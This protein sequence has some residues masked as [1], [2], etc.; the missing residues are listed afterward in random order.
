MVNAL[1]MRQNLTCQLHDS[2]VRALADQRENRRQQQS[3]PVL[4]SQEQDTGSFVVVAKS[5]CTCFGVLVQSSTHKQ[6]VCAPN[7]CSAQQAG[8]MPLIY[9]FVAHG[10]SVLAEFT[11]YHGNFNSVA[12]ECLQRLQPGKPRPQPGCT[13][14]WR[15]VLAATGRPDHPAVLDVQLLKTG[16]ATVEQ[17]KTS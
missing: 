6:A 13:H 14:A 7:Y 3:V 10:T 16:N 15:C 11:P 4:F 8:S 5:V 1:M 2:L 12:L 9:S 17:A